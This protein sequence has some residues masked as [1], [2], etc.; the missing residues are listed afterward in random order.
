MYKITVFDSNS[1][2]LFDS[3]VSF[4]AEDTMILEELDPAVVEQ[5]ETKIL[6]EKEIV[7]DDVTFEAVNAYGLTQTYHVGHWECRFL[8][9]DFGGTGYRIAQYDASGV[10]MMDHFFGRLRA[11]FCHGN[12]VLE[13]EVVYQPIYTYRVPQELWESPVYADFRENRISTKCYLTSRTFQNIEDM[14]TD[15]QTFEVTEEIMDELFAD[16]IGEAG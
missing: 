14:Q 16:V 3:E 12:P 10:C 5:E 1:S 6:Y 11:V 7:L 4:F 13:N 15:Y 8:W 9:I 2:M